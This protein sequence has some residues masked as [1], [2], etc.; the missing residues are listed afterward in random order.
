MEDIIM[1]YQ[2]QILSL[3]TQMA[4]IWLHF[5]LAVLTTGVWAPVWLWKWGFNTAIKTQI[6]SMRIAASV[7]AS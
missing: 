3:E 5:I 1:N 4:N 7:G 6:Q 2:Q